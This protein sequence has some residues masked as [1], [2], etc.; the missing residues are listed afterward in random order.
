MAPK[1]VRQSQISNAE[2]VSPANGYLKFSQM[3]ELKDN[4]KII[5]LK[6]NNTEDHCVR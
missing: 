3:W 1:L 4:L 6:T 2:L 5:Y